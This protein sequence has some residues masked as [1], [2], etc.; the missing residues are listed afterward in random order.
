[1]DEKADDQ[2]I[3]LP[4]GRIAE[5]TARDSDDQDKSKTVRRLRVADTLR[6][7]E[8]R[9][10]I[11]PTQ[12]RAGDEFRADFQT[13]ALHGIRPRAMERI[14]ME[15]K[16]DNRLSRADHCKRRVLAD[17]EALGG[18]GSI[19]STVMWEVIGREI[20]LREWCDIC[21]L[22]RAVVTG[23]LIASLDVIV[24]NRKIA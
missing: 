18:I 15:W 7:L 24:R 16:S 3:G 1:M 5:V 14:D 13:A 8:M 6:R 21:G 22:A 2:V 4:G 10:T 17:L 23:I 20:S 11:T 19:G 9:K 12:R